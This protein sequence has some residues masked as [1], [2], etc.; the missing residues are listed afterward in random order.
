MQRLIGHVDADCYYVSAERVRYRSLRGIP[1]GV[2]SN[3]GAC[4]I[5]RSYELKAKGVTVALPIWDA[6][7]LC[8]D[9][10][11]IK[12]DFRWY[13][14]LSRRMLD[15]LKE[16]SPRVEFYSIDEM[17]F[18]ANGWAVDQAEELQR[19][20]LRDIGV[21][22][23]VG[24]AP[25]KT[26]AKFASDFMKPFGCFAATGDDDRRKL[27]EG[28]PITE[29]TGIAK[30]SARKLARHGITTCDQFAAAYP[31]L[32]R[33]LMTVKGEQLLMELN[34][35]PCFP[36]A[37]QRADAQSIGPRRFSRRRNQ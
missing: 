5:A 3:Q 31:R 13:E 23:S 34:G 32:I 15:V 33:K 18:E 19:A 6:V 24:I 22:V 20:V 25:T 16:R 8:S 14:V 9:A 36:I 26:L 27:I 17:F 10:V 7:P 35:V 2:L 12:R 37:T 28:Q 4:V 1:C 29:V 11:Y 21:P 30:R